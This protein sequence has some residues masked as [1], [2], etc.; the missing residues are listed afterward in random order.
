MC[1]S[2]DSLSF[3]FDDDN[4][5]Q[6]I[7]DAISALLLI[8]ATSLFV[9]FN[10]TQHEIASKLDLYTYTTCKAHI[11]VVVTSP[12]HRV[13]KNESTDLG[14]YYLKGYLNELKLGERPELDYGYL[15]GSVAC[16]IGIAIS[17]FI[18]NRI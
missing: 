16:V 14:C 17:Q 9:Y 13:F 3:D 10:T 4:R 18:R 11:T 15:I 8:G 2:T 1:P 12:I 7:L 5:K 6:F